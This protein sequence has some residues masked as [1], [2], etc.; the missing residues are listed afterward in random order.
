MLFATGD[1]VPRDLKVRQIA[2]LNFRDR[3]RIDGTSVGV[4]EV[5][6]GCGRHGLFVRSFVRS[7]V[8]LF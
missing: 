1:A 2:L 8:S 3:G 4:G 5:A 6:V 7:F